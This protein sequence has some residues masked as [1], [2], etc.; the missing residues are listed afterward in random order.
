M[1][2]KIAVFYTIAQVNDWWST[3][4]FEKQINRLKTSGLYN[5]IDF[6]D[7]LVVGSNHLP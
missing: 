1:N 4:F 6:I 2:D 7:V 5:N 3:E